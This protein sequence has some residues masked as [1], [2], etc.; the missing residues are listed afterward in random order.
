MSE[1]ETEAH[2]RLE[3][4]ICFEPV[5]SKADPRFGLLNCE[6]P[7][8]I[9]CIRNWRSKVAFDANNIR[10]CP[11]CRTNT[12]FVVPSAVW[13]TD[14]EEKK[15]IIEAY[16]KKM[17]TIPC[18]YFDH[19]RANCPFGSSCFYT[20]KNID[21]SEDKRIPHLRTV[22]GENEKANVFKET[23]LSD[24]ITFPANPR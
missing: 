11:L 24:F 15:A 14:P 16:K 9:S 21:G 5:L 8:C 6:H 3:C 22:I 20:H 7:F 23:R 19:G 1:L 12:Y 4:G 18:K 10:S 13:V 2:R 17:S